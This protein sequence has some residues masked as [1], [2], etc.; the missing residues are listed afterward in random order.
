[1]SLGQ[2]IRGLGA[3]IRGLFGQKPIA[4]SDIAEGSGFGSLGN[5]DSTKPNPKSRKRTFITIIVLALIPLYYLIGAWFTHRI[6]DDLN[7]T[8]ADPGPGK[9]HTVAVVAELIDREVNQTKWS[10]NIQAFEPAALLRVG[11]NMVN[12]QTGIV[13]GIS[14]T[15][16]E[17]ENR[18]AR[19]RGTSSAD[20]DMSSARE[21]LAR[22]ADTWLW[23]GADSE[24]RKAKDAL[25]R[26]NTR[27]ASGQANFEQRAD[28]LQG[29]LDHVAFDL[30]AASNELDRELVAGRHKIIDFKADK[31]FYYAKGQS[32]A[33]F[34]I[35]RALREDYSDII[36][37][38]HLEKIYEEMLTE[39]ASAAELQPL[40]VQNAKPSALIMPNHLATEGFYILCARA[41]LREITDI[42]QR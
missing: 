16:Y 20:V 6:N 7:Y 22:S 17:M 10:P 28:N 19:M 36:K 26:Y 33:Y 30:G 42:L 39:L 32:Y 1:M 11:G 5:P 35:L 2:S 9:S 3:R 15:V 14:T 12:F 23:A 41:R 31:V 25:I 4:R 38:R 13:K 27:L 29:L 18:L 40:I 24:Y 21:G 34:I 37:E 8:I